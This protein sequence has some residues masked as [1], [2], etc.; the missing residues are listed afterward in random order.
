M[1]IQGEMNRVRM[2]LLLG[3][4]GI[5]PSV[6]LSQVNGA[7]GNAESQCPGDTV[8]QLGSQAA[9]ESRGFVARL[10]TAIDAN[11]SIKVSRMIRYPLA[12]HLGEQTFRVHTPKEFL[13]EYDRIMNRAVRTT[14]DDPQSSKCLFSTHN[15]FMI[16]N[17]EVWFRKMP[18]GVYKVIAI[19]LG[20]V[21]VQ[22]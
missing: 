19:N 4:L 17:G 18:A 16:G 3:F 1:S 11:D 6:C 10:K 2:F 9:T 7:A 14:I 8:D 5:A 22:Q 20:A 12:V 21:P 13:H 15:D